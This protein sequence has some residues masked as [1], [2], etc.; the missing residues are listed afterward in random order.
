MD[1]YKNV[2]KEIHSSTLKKAFDSVNRNALWAV[3]RKSGFTG[4]LYRALKGIYTSVTAY[5]RDICSSSVHGE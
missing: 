2:C 4:K 3:L 5:V 1:M